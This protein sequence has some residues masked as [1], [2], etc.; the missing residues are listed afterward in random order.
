[1]L[2]VRAAAFAAWRAGGGAERELGTGATA[3]T[4][5]ADRR[6]AP[7]TLAAS[8]PLPAN[9]NAPAELI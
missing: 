1:M 9:V 3:S 2:A 4:G 6:I 8:A 7:E 5:A